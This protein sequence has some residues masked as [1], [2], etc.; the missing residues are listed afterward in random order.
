L[1]WVGGGAIVFLVVCLAIPG[2]RA[3]FRFDL[4][5]ADDLALTTLAIMA[6]VALFVA[7]AR[8][9][10]WRPPGRPAASRGAW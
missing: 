8:L 10:R 2:L 7:V 3:L 4:L 5:H 9:L 1:R 6:I